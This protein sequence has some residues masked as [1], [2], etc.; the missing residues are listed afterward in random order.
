MTHDSH[1]MILVEVFTNPILVENTYSY[2]VN[3]TLDFDFKT[4]K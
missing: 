3:R 1:F 4:C 2:R